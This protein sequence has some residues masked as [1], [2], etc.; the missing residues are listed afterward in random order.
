MWFCFILNRKGTKKLRWSS[1]PLSKNQL[2]FPKQF[3]LYHLIYLG[4]PLE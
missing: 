1:T 3:F 4:H 2:I